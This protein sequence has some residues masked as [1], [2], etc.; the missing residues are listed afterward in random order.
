VNAIIRVALGHI[1]IPLKKGLTRNG[2]EGKK[3]YPDGMMGTIREE[4]PS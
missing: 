4:E 1:D 3:P 2:S